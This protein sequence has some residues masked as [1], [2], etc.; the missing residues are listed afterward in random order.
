MHLSRHNAD[1]K[2][3][4]KGTEQQGKVQFNALV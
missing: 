4:L 3:T 1:N 2:G